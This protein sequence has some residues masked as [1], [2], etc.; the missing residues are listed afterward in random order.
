MSFRLFLVRLDENS[1]LIAFR[2]ANSP[3]IFI[4]RGFRESGNRG[5]TICH[6]S[7]I[8]ETKTYYPGFGFGVRGNFGEYFVLDLKSIRNFFLLKIFFF[9]SFFKS[10]E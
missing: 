4:P 3:A 5:I 7:G 6:S 8:R 1:G 2:D 10:K 9:K